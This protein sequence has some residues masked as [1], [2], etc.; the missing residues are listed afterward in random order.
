[1]LYTVGFHR[2]DLIRFGAKR[3]DGKREYYRNRLGRDQMK[4]IYEC[5]LHGLNLGNLGQHL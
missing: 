4:T 3:S 2:L 5:V 1:M